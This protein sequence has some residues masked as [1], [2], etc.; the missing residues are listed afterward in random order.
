MAPSRRANESFMFLGNFVAGAETRSFAPFVR[1]SERAE[2]GP[3]ILPTRQS[4]QIWS[5]KGS[6]LIPS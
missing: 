5:A 4:Q 6:C 1:T 3:V 2:Y